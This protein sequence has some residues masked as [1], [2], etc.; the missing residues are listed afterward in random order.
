MRQFYAEIKQWVVFDLFQMIKFALVGG[1]STLT[2]LVAG[3][4]LIHFVFERAFFANLGAYFIALP[5]SF[6]GHTL[7]TYKRKLS[8]F[9]F[10]KFFIVNTLIL[11]LTLVASFVMDNFQV[12]KYIA[13][14]I[15]IALF[16]M[17]SYVCHTLITFKRP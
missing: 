7:F 1:V 3:L 15:S 6:I 4:L 12:N 13:T 9:L 14:V 8:F 10:G 11:C 16:P 5:I 17:I 2:H